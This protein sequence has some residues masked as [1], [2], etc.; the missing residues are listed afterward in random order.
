MERSKVYSLDK[1]ELITLRA[2]IART[3]WHTS[4]K[5]WDR[6][7]DISATGANIVADALITGPLAG[8]LAERDALRAQV[9]AARGFLREW[10]WYDDAEHDVGMANDAD[11]VVG[12]R[13]ILNATDGE[14]A[15]LPEWDQQGCPVADADGGE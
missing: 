12:F 10:D 14:D 8:L 5:S 2:E 4:R 15:D 11:L 6:G 9:E 3:I 1:D 13:R 7:V